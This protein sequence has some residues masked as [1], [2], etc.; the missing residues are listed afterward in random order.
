M[1]SPQIDL[2]KK[3]PLQGEAIHQGYIPPGRYIDIDQKIYNEQPLPLDNNNQIQ[4]GGINDPSS[5]QLNNGIQPEKLVTN[6]GTY[7]YNQITGTS[8]NQ[9]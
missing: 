3:N 4:F 6:F 8:N 7:L 2:M 9:L 1:F 5:T